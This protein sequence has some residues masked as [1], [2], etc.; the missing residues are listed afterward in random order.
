MYQWLRRLYLRLRYW[1]RG[2]INEEKGRPVRDIIA[3]I[4][5]QDSPLLRELSE[6]NFS[7]VDWTTYKIVW[8]PEL[9]RAAGLLDEL[10]E[11]KD[12]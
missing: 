7:N 3:E 5:W 10:T 11:V 4:D 12:E 6:S 9:A 1:N 2:P 8:R